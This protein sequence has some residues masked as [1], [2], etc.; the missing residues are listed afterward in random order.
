MMMKKLI[1]STFL[2]TGLMSGVMAE[3]RVITTSAYITQVVEALGKERLLVGADTTS[4]YND[5]LKKLPDVGYRIALSTEGMLS[6]KPSLILWSSD[7]GPKNVV[8]QV[9]KSG[10]QT[11]VLAKPSN[12]DELK[13]LVTQVGEIFNEP[14][15]SEALKQSLEKKH[16]L[17]KDDMS[18]RGARKTLFIMEEMGGGGSKSFA[19]GDTS[20]TALID[21]LGLKNPFA[22]QFN[23]YKAVNLETQIQQDAEIVLIGTRKEFAEKNMPVIRK[24]V[25]SIGWPKP[26]QPKCVFE[27]DISHVLVY[28]VHLYDDALTLSRMI[29]ECLEE[30]K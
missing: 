7:S 4:R 27:V 21:L 20:A 1:I 3:E 24:D 11:Y 30:A 22:S 2:V 29:D 9:N 12:L 18:K 23:A 15:K 13:S 5:E 17:L 10:I 19:G 26:V 8:E 28:G 25:S 6:L 16:G 14:T